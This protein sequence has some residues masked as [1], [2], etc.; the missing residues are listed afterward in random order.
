MLARDLPV[1]GSSPV[2][3]T[4]M[5]YRHATFDD[6]RSVA[7]QVHC[8]TMTEPVRPVL[9]LRPAVLNFSL[10]ASS[11]ENLRSRKLRRT[12][13]AVRPRPRPIIIPHASP[14]VMMPPS[15]AFHLRCAGRA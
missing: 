8:E 5:P 7:A 12:V 4:V 13:M 14:E 11:S 15:S 6:C 2:W 9:T 1:W 10:L 3:H